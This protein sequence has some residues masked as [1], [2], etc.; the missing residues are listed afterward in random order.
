MI[1]LMLVVK[2]LRNLPNFIG[3]VFAKHIIKTVSEEKIN[4]RKA[5]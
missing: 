5:D 4:S 1:L 2:A 3:H